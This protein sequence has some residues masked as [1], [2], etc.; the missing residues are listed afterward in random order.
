MLFKMHVFE[1]KYIESSK[2]NIHV[3]YSLSDGH[4]IQTHPLNMDT[5]ISI[6]YVH[7]DFG[8]VHKSFVH[9]FNSI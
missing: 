5:L 7:I 9:N 3:F 4:Q 8:K 6:L 2:R 1:L